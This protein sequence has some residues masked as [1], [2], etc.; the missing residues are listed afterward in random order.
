M[1]RILF[2]LILGF[3]LAG[4]HRRTETRE[5][6]ANREMPSGTAV[7]RGP[8]LS[9]ADVVDQI[10]PAV[11]TIR[12]SKR[13]RAPRLFPFFNDPLFREFF[14]GSIPRQGGGEQVQR[15]LGSGVV[16]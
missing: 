8:L 10:A 7:A 3:G 11:V 9:Y 13:V 4:C 2:A 5:R 12:A 16:V 6:A 14:G 15:A 1:K